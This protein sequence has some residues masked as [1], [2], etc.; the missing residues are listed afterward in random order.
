M[1]DFYLFMVM[2]DIFREF[3]TR[4]TSDH[5]VCLEGVWG[6]SCLYLHSAKFRGLYTCNV[7]VS[8]RPPAPTYAVDPPQEKFSGTRIRRK[9]TYMA[10]ANFDLHITLLFLWFWLVKFCR[11]VC[12]LKF[13]FWRSFGQARFAQIILR[14]NIKSYRKQYPFPGCK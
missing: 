7:K 1:G 10:P 13:A 4:L 9:C 8:P 2:F 11:R 6:T 12:S 14:V 3:L 5:N